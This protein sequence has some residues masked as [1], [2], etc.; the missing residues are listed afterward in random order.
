MKSDQD[1]AAEEAEMSDS[2]FGKLCQSVKQAIAHARGEKKLSS[3]Q[4]R[5]VEYNEANQE[6]PQG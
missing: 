2:L 1:E 5:Q 4:T 6:R 3:T